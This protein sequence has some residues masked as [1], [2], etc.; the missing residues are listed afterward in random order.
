MPGIAGT[1]M[2]K[3]LQ[4]GLVLLGA[5]QDGQVLSLA[6]TVALTPEEIAFAGAEIE[7][8]I[9]AVRST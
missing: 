4:R 2:T 6:P 9:R 3:G 5:G 8:L 7:K 1:L